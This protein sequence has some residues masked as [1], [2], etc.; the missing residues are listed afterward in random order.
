VELASRIAFHAGELAVRRALRG[1]DAVHLASA[2]EAMDAGG[3]LLTFDRQL[4]SAA[5]AE[6][7]SV[8]PTG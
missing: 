1:Y 4:A 6:G 2:L 3:V 7:L 5:L 8:A